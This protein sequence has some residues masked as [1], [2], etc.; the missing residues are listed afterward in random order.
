LVLAID[1]GTSWCKA[2]YIDPQGR[3]VSMSRAFVRDIA[4]TGDGSAALE[5]SWQTLAQVVRE[6]GA[7]LNPGQRAAGPAAIGTSFRS[8]LG[9]FLDERG[10]P[11]APPDD[12]RQV[13]G[14][15]VLAE[16]YAMPGWGDE[17]PWAWGY[18]TRLV[19]VIHWLRH[20]D[21]ETW[22]RIDRA[23]SLRDL[24]AWRMTGRW[25]T[26]PTTG[27]GRLH[28]PQGMPEMTGLAMTA[29]PDVEPIDAVVGT[30]QPDAA[31]DLGLPAGIPVVAGLHDGPAANVGTGMIEPG[32]VTLTLGTN[33]VFRAVNGPRLPDCFG[34]VI[35]PERWAWVNNVPS[36]AA[37]LDVVASELTGMPVS[38]V[39]HAPLSEAATHVTP[40]SNGLVFE[41][42]PYGQQERQREQVRRARAAGHAD[43]VIYRA[44]MESI[45]RGERWLYE[46]SSGDGTRPRRY[47]ATGGCSRN[48]ELVRIIAS[49]LGAPVGVGN[50]E[51]G[52]L[53]AAL[54]AASGIGW[55]H[56]VP[57]AVA[58]AVRTESCVQPDPSATAIYH[59]MY[60]RLEA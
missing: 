1:M 45:G 34:Y 40:G 11:F 58:A 23:G 33:F 22:S 55:Y 5:R 30:L 15:E 49:S 10:V 7:G 52:L 37:Q 13:K 57:A 20:H 50:P 27:P 35:L 59:E 17:G 41:R 38:A 19:A 26:D 48:R 16:V 29:F 18:A 43:P 6:A 51:A 24:V 14:S 54:A 3:I 31:A 9:V 36:A 28:W 21:P 44:L 46:W 2:G 60:P 56:S 8:M 32:D 4:P 53:G 42:F 47:T 25:V 12:A 39:A